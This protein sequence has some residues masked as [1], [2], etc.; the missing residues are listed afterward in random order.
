MWRAAAALVGDAIAGV[1]DENAPHDHGRQAHQ[2][3]AV[4]PIDLPLIQ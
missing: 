2:L 3:R 4:G 1:V